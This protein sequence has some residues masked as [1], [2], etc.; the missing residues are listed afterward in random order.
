MNRNHRYAFNLP[1]RGIV[2]SAIFY[3]GLSFLSAHLA[4]DFSGIIFVGLIALSALFAVLS[5]F[6][7]IR[8]LV[9][10]RALELTEDAILFPRGFPRTRI[11]RI[12]YA[13]IIALRDSALGSNVSFA[14]KHPEELLKLELSASPTLKATPL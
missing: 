6:M 1:W 4:K 8:R 14:W 9:F 12:L 5:L 7:M 3:A 2:V 11:T 10:P 13:E